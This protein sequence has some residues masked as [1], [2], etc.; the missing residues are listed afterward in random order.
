MSQQPLANKYQSPGICSSLSSIKA[1]K[2]FPFALISS[3]VQAGARADPLWRDSWAWRWG[4]KAT[5]RPSSYDGKDKMT[6][7]TSRDEFPPRVVRINLRH[8]VR[9]SDIWEE[10]KVQLLHVEKS[11]LRWLWEFGQRAS[12]TPSMSIWR[13][14]TWGRPEGLYLSA[15]PGTFWDFPWG[16]GGSGWGEKRLSLTAEA[17]T[18]AIRIC[19]RWDEMMNICSD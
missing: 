6:N 15:G 11:Q 2:H 12:W 7:R 3:T 9:S 1:S 17:A 16:A 13:G 8:K 14:R 10:L 19:G 18:T 4:Y 5:F